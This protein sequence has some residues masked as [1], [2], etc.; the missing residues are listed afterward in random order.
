V[1]PFTAKPA[2]ALPVEILDRLETVERRQ[3]ELQLEWLSTLDQVQRQVA[4]LVKREQR[5]SPVEPRPENGK[6][7]NPNQTLLD[8]L[9]SRHAL[10]HGP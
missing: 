7:S 10:P 4:R 6:G 2:T 5:E 1:W 8:L 3:R 9:R